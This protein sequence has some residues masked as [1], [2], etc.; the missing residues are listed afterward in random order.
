M[1]RT[2]AERGPVLSHMSMKLM[3]VHSTSEIRIRTRS[4][5]F[6]KCLHLI[7][8]AKMHY[9][10]SVQHTSP[11]LQPVCTTHICLLQG[12]VSGEVLTALHQ[13]RWGVSEREGSTCLSLD[14]WNASSSSCIGWTAVLCIAHTLKEQIFFKG[15][16]ASVHLI[17]HLYVIAIRKQLMSVLL[18]CLWPYT[19]VLHL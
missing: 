6:T 18:I 3:S 1:L 11:C 2:G 9:K 13:A 12:E 5:D 4:L 17:S 19:N 15:L 14:H 8:K 16:F 10:L 7:Y